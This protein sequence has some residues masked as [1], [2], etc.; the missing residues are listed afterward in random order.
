ME[1]NINLKDYLPIN[2]RAKTC[3]LKYL[4]HLVKFEDNSQY[5]NPKNIKIDIFSTSEKSIINKIYY[6]MIIKNN[7]YNPKFDLKKNI[8][9]YEK[10]R[11]FFYQLKDECNNKINDNEI[12]IKVDFLPFIQSKMLI[13][14]NFF[15][16]FYYN[17]KIF[18]KFIIKP[19]NDDDFKD[20]KS[21]LFIY[22]DGIG[23]ET[24]VFNLENDLN[25]II[26]IKNIWKI[27]SYI[28]IIIPV[29]NKNK[30]IEIHNNL[31]IFL[32]M[33]KDENFKVSVIYLSD[34]INDG[35]A[36]NIFF[37]FYKTKN[38][39]YFFILNN[40]IV[41]K[42]KEYS[43]MLKELNNY[44]D[45]VY[46]KND[47]VQIKENQIYMQ[48]MNDLK[49]FMFLTNF[50]NDLSNLRY[51]FDFYYNINFSMILSDSNHKFKLDTIERVEIGG[52]L[53]TEEY[54]KFKKYFDNINND[55][56]IFKLKE[57]KTINI[58][59]DFPAN[60]Y[61][62]VCKN[63]IP[64]DKEL[65]YCYFCKDFYCYKCVKDNFESKSG[66]EKFIDQKHNLLFFKTRNKNQ[67]LNIEEH[68]LGKNTFT[69]IQSFKSYHSASCDGCSSSFDGSPRYICITCKPGLYLSGGYNDYCDV[70]IDHMMKNDDAGKKMQKDIKTINYNSNFVSNHILRNI[71]NHENH[72]YLMVAL[73]GIGTTYQG[74]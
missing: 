14:F 69:T 54:N 19:N 71:H 16:F 47:P 30:A 63:I 25:K 50:I 65:Y 7:N 36:I 5:M 52:S 20:N 53:K 45:L 60:I 51:I 24:K 61:C 38:K 39:N 73:E 2:S 35:A 17:G 6:S 34:D 49:L 10:M 57:I 18:H 64:N 43:V 29:S 27:F 41:Y 3:L 4:L 62:K 72:I 56:F 32:K 58:N 46:G 40:N 11:T 66:K 13:D 74:F 21:K 28:Y 55:N 67:F 31:P 70:C 9:I 42:I 1:N 37:N 33:K 15:N 59:I 8:P 22:F 68:K 26:S 12:S 44:I 23:N 48:K